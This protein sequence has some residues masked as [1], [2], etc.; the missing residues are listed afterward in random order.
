VQLI[1]QGPN[2][3]AA[4]SY[5]ERHLPKDARFRWDPAKRH[6]WTDKVEIAAKLAEY[7]TD[8]VRDELTAHFTARTA[9]K[10][11]KAENV[12]ASRAVDIVSDVAFN[13]P[14]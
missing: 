13:I 4:S 8:D 1:K 9:E 10:A 12:T 2:W 3:I 14:R 6:W 11:E 5:D 7:A